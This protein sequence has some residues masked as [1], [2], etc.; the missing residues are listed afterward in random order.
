MESN[1]LEFKMMGK[2]SLPALHYAF[3]Q[4]FGDY[5]VS[6]ANDL[7]ALKYRLNKIGA[8]LDLSPAI[9]QDEAVL[10]FIIQALG[11]YK[12]LK[13]AYNG[14]TGVLPTFRGRGLAVKLYRFAF[15]KLKEQQVKQCLLEV[16]E[17]NE[18]ALKAY[19]Q[20]GFEVS[21]TMHCYLGEPS[22]NLKGNKSI[23]LLPVKDRLPDWQLYRSF[24]DFEP[25]WQNSIDSVIRNFQ[26]ETIIEAVYRTKTV[27]F[28]IF[29]PLKSR[30]T[31][32]A[33]HPEH[34]VMGIGIQLL[35][36]ASQMCLKKE[37]AILNID[38]QAKAT[39][40]FLHRCGMVKKVTQFEMLR[41]LF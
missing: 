16:V 33:V 38:V 18:P 40:R 15:E 27:G 12:G 24:F 34:R 32:L 1:Q 19:R 22:K 23:Q 4:S 8:N 9:W 11:N 21:R 35:R 2:G 14:G 36:A 28:V 13:T 31:Q 39:N 10:A 20:L 3:E 26:N 5:Q 17:N 30:V 6:V 25:C 7:E 29:E 37:L 41:P